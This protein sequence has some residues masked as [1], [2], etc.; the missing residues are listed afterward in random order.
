LSASF[1]ERGHRL[2]ARRKWDQALQAY[3]QAHAEQER[4][5]KAGSGNLEATNDWPMLLD[6][7]AALQ[8]PSG[9]RK[10]GMPETAVRCAARGT[11]QS[12]ALCCFKATW[13]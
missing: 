3:Q 7:G 11:S 9:T 1:R 4:V 2:A 12:D 13:D 8:Q 5:V 10:P 6:M